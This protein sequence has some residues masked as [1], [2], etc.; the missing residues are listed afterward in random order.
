M[1]RLN[2]DVDNALFYKRYRIIEHSW[3]KRN[4]KTNSMMMNSADVIFSLNEEMDAMGEQ[5]F[6]NIHFETYAEKFTEADKRLSTLEALQVK[7][8]S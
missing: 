6:V 5:Q 7:Q 8:L 1:D 4:S 3:A 2:R